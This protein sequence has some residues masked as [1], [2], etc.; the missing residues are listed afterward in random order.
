M[1]IS[2]CKELTFSEIVVEIEADGTALTMGY[3]RLEDKDGNVN[4]DYSISYDPIEPEE[5]EKLEEEYQKYRTKNE[6][7]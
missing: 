7:V 3:N 4:W 2:K 1:K 5:M 6:K